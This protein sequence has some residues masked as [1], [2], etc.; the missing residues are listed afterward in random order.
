MTIKKKEKIRI[1]LESFDPQILNIA[2]QKITDS[3][4]KTKSKIIGPIPLP[5]RKKIYCVLRS[6][7]VNKDSR[8]HFEIRRHAKFFD[9]YP[10]PNIA[11][12]LLNINLPPGVSTLIK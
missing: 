12:S 10:R 2:C 4:K 8:E 6:P 11:L 7:H 3:I 5:T 1:K 9:I